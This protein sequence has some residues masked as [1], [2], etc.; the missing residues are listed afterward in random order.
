MAVRDNCD[1]L[2]INLLLRRQHAIERT[3]W[4]PIVVYQRRGAYAASDWMRWLAGFSHS[5]P[6]PLPIEEA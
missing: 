3:W 1:M 5:W 6:K 4:P 2:I